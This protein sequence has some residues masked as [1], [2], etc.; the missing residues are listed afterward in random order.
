[1]TACH[2]DTTA[3]QSTGSEVVVLQITNIHSNNNRDVVVSLWL[4]KDFKETP[5]CPQS[6]LC[7]QLGFQLN[8][9]RHGDLTYD[10]WERW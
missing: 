3:A 8:S 7:G 9:I 10:N 5:T 4:L 2:E 6:L 1:M